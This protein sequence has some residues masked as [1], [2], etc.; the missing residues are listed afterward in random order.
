MI[1]YL[2][3]YLTQK[4]G[5]FNDGLPLLGHEIQTLSLSLPPAITCLW[6]LKRSK[7]RHFVFVTG[8]KDIVITDM[9]LY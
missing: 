8:K 7:C 5:F 6:R 9:L 2:L 3:V 4:L 1:N